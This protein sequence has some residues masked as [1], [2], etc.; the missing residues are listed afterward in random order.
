MSANDNE[1][2]TVDAQLSYIA[3]TAEIVSAYVAN[4]RLQPSELEALI[5]SVHTILGGLGKSTE[6]AEPA[7][8]KPT[9]AQIRKSIT[10]DALISFIDGK[11]YKTLKR[12]LTKHGLDPVS[13]RQRYGLPADYPATASS[14]SAARSALA[15]DLGLGRKPKSAVAEAAVASAP[16]EPVADP[17]PRGRRKKAGPAA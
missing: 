7:F 2:D 1:A 17:K 3:L 16:E 6:P 11:A 9:P 13:Y 8:E 10:P 14:Y 12:H 5:A 4:N 15:R